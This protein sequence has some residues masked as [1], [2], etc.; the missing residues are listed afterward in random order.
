[1]TPH[2]I[3]RTLITRIAWITVRLERD[4]GSEGT[5]AAQ[6]EEADATRAL[7]EMT[8]YWEQD[9]FDRAVEFARK[10]IDARGAFE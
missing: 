10:K 4:H 8:G 5:R 6:R 1:M 3:K 7:L 9:R 2:K